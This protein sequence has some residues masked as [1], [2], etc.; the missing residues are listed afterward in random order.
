M[1]FKP[2]CLD[3][4]P[5]SP[6]P[7]DAHKPRS[8]S[9]KPPRSKDLAGRSWSHDLTADPPQANEALHQCQQR[10]A[11]VLEA[12]GYGLYEFDARTGKIVGSPEYARILGYPPEAF[13]ET[14]EAWDQ[15]I[16]PED[17]DRLG[18]VIH[19][20]LAGETA[21]Y[22]SEF[23]IAV[24]PSGWKWVSARGQVVERHETG[25]PLRL[26][27]T[28][29]DRTERNPASPAADPFFKCLVENACIAVALSNTEGTILFASPSVAEMLGVGLSALIGRNV[30]EFLHPEDVAHGKAMYR[31]LVQGPQNTFK[32]ELRY[33]HPD[34]SYHVVEMDAANC[35]QCPITQ[36]IVLSFR[37]ITDRVRAVEALRQKEDHLDLAL[38]VSRQGLYEFNAKTGCVAV[39]TKYAR[40]LG[41][42]DEELEASVAAWVERVHP[43]DREAILTASARCYSG[44]ADSY[45]SEL[46][47][48]SSSGKWIWISCAGKVVEWDAEG[49]PLRIVGTYSDITE[50]RQ[51]QDQFKQLQSELAYVGRMSTMG[52]LATGL[53]HELNQ[54]LASL[55]L[56]AQTCRDL[57]DSD[58]SLAHLR[59]PL[60]DIA[61]LAQRTSEI[62]RRL[63]RFVRRRPA[64]RSTANI[65]R[66]IQ[67]VADL[68][69]FELRK[70]RVSLRME[71]TEG[72]PLVVVDSTQIQQVLLNLLR[73]AVQALENQPTNQRRILVRTTL[74]A[75]RK[76]LVAVHDTGPGVAEDMVT[77]IFEPFVTTK[78]DGMGV[79]LAISRSIVQDHEGQLWYSPGTPNGSVFQFTLPTLPP[80]TPDEP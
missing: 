1:V 60:E 65:N 77:H 37:E 66:L 18:A 26:L 46:R 39:S 67:E 49:L 32:A 63:R 43:D 12:S 15:R 52:E 30:F 58:A 42:G 47:V 23:R 4:S 54:P 69:E 45:Q 62:I 36:G 20:C 79:G 56:Y 59:Q 76:I 8:P 11:L 7:P 19:Q 21:W 80:E 27:S 74:R 41:F 2:Y 64:C 70:H 35:L 68:T 10:L 72:L 6:S 25:Y 51:V 13:E 33:R 29:S 61:A 16:H 48:R 50:Q 9:A 34:G 3:Y 73:N 38:A 22:Q 5:E 44:E 40:L 24:H 57:L 31:N 53:A 55:K 17:R 28:L 78:P 14:A 75:D 71:L